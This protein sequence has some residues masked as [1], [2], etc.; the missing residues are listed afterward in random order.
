M[1]ARP[2]T[3]TSSSAWDRRFDERLMKIRSK[4]WCA[5]ILLGGIACAANAQNAP[6]VLDRVVAVVNNRAVLWSDITDAMHLAAL[7]TRVKGEED[8]NARTA[9]E[10]LVS[11]TLIQQQIRQEDAEAMAPAEK[12]LQARLTELRKELPACVH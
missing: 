3:S 5:A 8:P 10:Q 7:E 1:W 2:A 12:D 11:R 9:L 4:A 6:E